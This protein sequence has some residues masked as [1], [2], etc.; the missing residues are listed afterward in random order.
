MRETLLMGVDAGG[1]TCR[2]R[3]ETAGG[4][5]V[6]N[7]RSGPATL[8]LGGIA[9]AASIAEAT[10][11]AVQEAGLPAEAISELRVC[12]GI[13]SSERPGS[14]DELKTALLPHGIKDVVA[15]SDAH[16][17]C[18]GAHKGADGGIII[19]G[20]GSIGYGL[21]GGQ[22]RRV[23]GHGFP[24][25]DEGSG[26]FIGLHAARL[27][28]AAADGL[29]PA[30]SF[31]DAVYASMGGSVADVAHWLA[32]AHATD[33]AALAPIVVND[34]GPQA[35]QLLQLAGSHIGQFAMG[36]VGKG[37]EK[38]ALIGGLAPLIETHLPLDAKAHIV[39]AQAGPIDGAL[40]MLR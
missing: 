15:V 36:L 4:R 12:I 5:I 32:R 22:V 23:G 11:Q 6:G 34:G 8:R 35:E 18:V 21:A 25:S 40:L 38:I 33:Y 30:T 27:A 17:A 1:S 14:I 28:L 16:I 39:D 3:I 9:A 10:R 19:I 7:G 20:T 24:T 31:T 2:V 13:A 26:A 29:I 37:V